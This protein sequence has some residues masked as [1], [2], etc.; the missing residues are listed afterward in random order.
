MNEYKKAMTQTEMPADCETRIRAMLV[1]GKK[2]ESRSP[3]RKI[4]RMTAAAA[5]AVLLLMGGTLA[6]SGGWNDLVDIFR[7][8][9]GDI[10]TDA[11]IAQITELEEDVGLSAESGGITVTVDS[12]LTG[13]DTVDVLLKVDAPDVKLDP[14]GNYGFYNFKYSVMQERTNHFGLLPAGVQFE[15]LSIEEE[16]GQ[17]YI[18]F[19]YEHD[20]TT[21]MNLRTGEYIMQITLEDFYQFGDSRGDKIAIY[22][23]VW[24]FEFPLQELS[25][26]NS[27]IIED[28]E[29]AGIR[30]GEDGERECV[31]RMVDEVVISATSLILYLEED[32]DG[33]YLTAFDIQG[34]LDNG[35]VIQ[36]E[37]RDGYNEGGNWVQGYRWE[38]ILDL[39]ELDH[40][41]VGGQVVSLPGE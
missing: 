41:L 27:V 40:L 3:G 14:D 19:H 22:E 39:T 10:Y 13:D 16:T 18:L 2:R 17:V 25:R 36:A 5:A 4:L 26:N 11:Q 6:V 7:A 21:S 38:E 31:I 33:R 30:R 1:P 28:I 9:N 35:T 34:V 32:A 20:A 12:V 8:R 15:L 29:M 37:S 23:G 24:E